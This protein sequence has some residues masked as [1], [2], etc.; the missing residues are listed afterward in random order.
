MFLARLRMFL[1]T[2]E[3]HIQNN[4]FT[5]QSYKSSEVARDDSAS[6]PPTSLGT[7]YIHSFVSS[8]VNSAINS[9]FQQSQ[10]PQIFSEHLLCAKHWGSAKQ[11]REKL[12]QYGRE[13]LNVENKPSPVEVQ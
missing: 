13:D 3:Q 12:M 1:N 11:K 8:F 6:H 10:G 2:H 7:R 4:T 9:F 5:C